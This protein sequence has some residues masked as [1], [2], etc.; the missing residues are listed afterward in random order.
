MAETVWA[1]H[2][3]KVSFNTLLVDGTKI[4]A[5]ASKQSFH[6]EKD[7]RIRDGVAEVVGATVVTPESGENARQSKRRVSGR[8][9][10]QGYEAAAKMLKSRQAAVRFIA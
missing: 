2:R 9:G 5:R 3:A 1:L 7:L 10:N 8:S 4:D 6:K